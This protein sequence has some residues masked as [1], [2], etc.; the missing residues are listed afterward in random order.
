MTGILEMLI[1]DSGQICSHVKTPFAL[2]ISYRHSCHT[3]MWNAE[4]LPSLGGERRLH[5][6]H[7]CRFRMPPDPRWNGE[8]A[9]TPW[10]RPCNRPRYDF[11]MCFDWKISHLWRPAEGVRTITQR[12]ALSK[13][14]VLP[15]RMGGQ[16]ACSFPV[17]DFKVAD[18]R[19]GTCAELHDGGSS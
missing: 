7:M 15:H 6:H 2:I 5:A 18:F 1:S 12:E 11:T 4:K 3:Y 19:W 13:H 17:C 16:T 8:R 9:T 10:C 14:Q